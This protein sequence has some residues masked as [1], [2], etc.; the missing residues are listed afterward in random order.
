MGISGSDDE[1]EDR[2]KQD[3][4]QSC[5]NSLIDVWLHVSPEH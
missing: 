3:G 2:K 5:Q 4:M 1:S